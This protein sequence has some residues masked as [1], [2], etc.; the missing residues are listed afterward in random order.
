MVHKRLGSWRYVVCSPPARLIWC[1]SMADIYLWISIGYH[2]P[3][4]ILFLHLFYECNR[5]VSTVLTHIHT[6]TLTRR[7]IH[8][9][10]SKNCMFSREIVIPNWLMCC[11]M[12]SQHSR[13]VVRRARTSMLGLWYGTCDMINIIS[14]WYIEA[15]TLGVFPIFIMLFIW[16]R[17]IRRCGEWE[18][19][20]GCSPGLSHSNLR[21]KVK[22]HFF[23][24]QST[25]YGWMSVPGES[26]SNRGKPYE[27]MLVPAWHIE[28]ARAGCCT[29]I[30][31][32][33]CFYHSSAQ[34]LRRWAEIC[35]GVSGIAMWRA[36]NIIWSMHI[37]L[38]SAS[39]SSGHRQ[40][41]QLHLSTSHI[42]AF[43]W[44]FSITL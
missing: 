9:T 44:A 2:N 3:F 8:N 40:L 38:S 36:N 33:K 14:L 12:L 1:I 11:G 16:K 15:Q 32:V 42:Y 20:D 19:I 43:P 29:N 10:C 6:H 13:K 35:S 17:H 23:A 26:V 5:L 39:R 31:I 37:S 28:T 24:F 21:R 7:H 41:K 22:R 25:W 4:S 30:E 18:K 27:N 34:S